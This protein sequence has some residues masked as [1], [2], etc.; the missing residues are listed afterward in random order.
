MTGAAHSFL[1]ESGW[2]FPLGRGFVLFWFSDGD[3]HHRLYPGRKIFSPSDPVSLG[4]AAFDGAS[5]VHSSD[6]SE[7]EGEQYA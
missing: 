7:N 3:C 6:R 5:F 1:Y 4:F 2:Q